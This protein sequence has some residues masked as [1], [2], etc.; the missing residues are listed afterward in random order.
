M[1]FGL[2]QSDH[3][4]DIL[5]VKLHRRI[6]VNVVGIEPTMLFKDLI[7]SQVRPTNMRLTFISVIIRNLLGHYYAS[8]GKQITR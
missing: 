2:I 5:P 6:Q 4:S 3:N 8:D 7:Y 1:R